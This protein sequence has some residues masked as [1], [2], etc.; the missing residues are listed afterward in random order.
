MSKMIQIRNVPD[1][2]HRKIKV[3]AAQS[4]MTLS[5]YLLGEIERIA[6]LPTHDEM[7]ARLHARSRVKLRTPGRS[8]YSEG[9]RLRMIVVDASAI[10]EFLL[11]TE[12]GS[13]VE[14]RLYSNDE[15]LHAPH[16]LDVEV[17]SALRRLFMPARSTPIARKKPSKTCNC[18]ESS[19][20]AIWI[21]RRGL[22][23]CA[24][25]SRRTTRYTLLS[26]NRSMPRYSPATIRSRAPLS[27]ERESN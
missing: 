17:L 2:V 16:L 20:M 27:G 21:S 24:R 18:C 7:L 5:D 9:T 11:Q 8:D 23:S 10:T 12:L 19:G 13:R 1:A 26:P 15:D 22:G 4:G 14:C 25:T 6:A 3:R